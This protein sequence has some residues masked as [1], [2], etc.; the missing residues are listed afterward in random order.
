MVPQSV[1]FQHKSWVVLVQD[2]CWN[3]FL[4]FVLSDRIDKPIENGATAVENF[5]VESGRVEC[6]VCAC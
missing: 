2:V 1:G 6:G 4:S 3:F 5:Q